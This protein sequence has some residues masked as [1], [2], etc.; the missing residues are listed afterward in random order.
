MNTEPKRDRTWQEDLQ[1]FVPGPQV[2][3]A[4]AVLMICLVLF[5]WKT[6]LFG[7]LWATWQLDDYQHGPFVPLFSL[8]LLWYRRDMI[9]PFAG[10]GSWWGLAFLA[11][12]IVMRWLAVYFN[13]GSLPEYSIVPFLAGLALFVGGWQALRWSWPS[14]VFLLFMLPLPG[15]VQSLLSLPLQGIAARTS[16]FIIQ[17][18]GIASMAQGHKIEISGAAEPLDVEQACSG[19]R[20]MMMFVAMCVGAAFIVRKPVWE[21]IFIT[22]SAIPIAVL[23][24]VA[25]ITVTAICYK[26]ALNN[27]SLADPA[28]VLHFVHD[29]AGYLIEMPAGMLLLWI[30]LTLLSKLLISP[31]PERALVM[32][33]LTEG[34]GPLAVQ[35]NP[36]YGKRT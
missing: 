36:R 5:W 32:G 1:Q 10:R 7:G 6:G 27:P 11:F 4:A 15:D 20:M 3:V 22:I 24:N 9:I 2:L 34:R 13:F 18:L 19:L 16:T 26:I 30:E 33:G 25:R 28:K 29:W 12:S 31:L 23:G 14:I 8:F 21:K 17:T 35:Q